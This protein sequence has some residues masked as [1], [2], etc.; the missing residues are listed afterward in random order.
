MLKRL[1]VTLVAV[2]VVGWAAYTQAS[3]I[4]Y[5]ETFA[6]GSTATL[7]TERELHAAWLLYRGCQSKSH[8]DFR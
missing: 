3:A 4:S 6:Y 2:L 5:N 8:V 7:A 1:Y